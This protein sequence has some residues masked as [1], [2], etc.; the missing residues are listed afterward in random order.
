MI[1]VP[2][3]A[4]V[5]LDAGGVR[6]DDIEISLDDE[7]RLDF[8][9]RVAGEIDPEDRDRL[10]IR[11]A[12]GAVQILRL[13]VAERP[14]SEAEHLTAVVTNREDETIAE[15]VPRA[16]SH[17]RMREP[18]VHEL[19]D[20][21]PLSGEVAGERVLAGAAGGCEPDAELSS[22]RL[23]HTALL[24]ERAAR[25]ACRGRPEHVLVVGLRL[26]VE[27]DRAAALASGALAGV[28][29]ALQLDAR[30]VGQ[31]FERLT[32]VD[33]LDLLDELEQVPALMASVAVPDLALGAHGEG[34]RLLGVERAQSRHLSAGAVEGD[35]PPD[36]LDQVEAR[37]D[38]C[39]SI[40]SHGPPAPKAA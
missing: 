12:V 26:G 19:L 18:R 16:T 30:A 7:R 15:A 3:L 1:A 33:A 38:L 25:R 2:L 6:R 37:L 17:G 10:V 11:A 14:A 36:H 29:P 31:Q 13:G 40:T 21:R 20:I 34:R 28:R 22:H 5:E 27:L 32:E 9:D 35:V 23:V 39:D 24:Q 8:C 4:T